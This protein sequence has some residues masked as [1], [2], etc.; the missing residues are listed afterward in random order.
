MQQQLSDVIG[1]IYD[2]IAHDDLC[3]KALSL[4]GSQVDGFLTTL[5]VFD[6]TTNTARLAQVACDDRERH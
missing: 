3:P 5:A 1:A 6:T 4:V 2:S